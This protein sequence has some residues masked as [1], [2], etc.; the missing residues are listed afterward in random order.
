ML[1]PLL[2]ALA[3]A[4]SPA[5]AADFPKAEFKL[6]LDEYS[7]DTM[8]FR[9]PSGLRVL[10][11]VD[12]T[13]P[14]VTVTNWFDRGSIHD[15]VNSKGESVEGIAHAVEHLAFRA[16]HG[17][18]PKN[19]DVINQLGGNL[20]AFTNQDATVYLT[21]APVDA[22]VPLL[23]IEAMRMDNGVR[24]VTAEDVEAEKA[25][26]RNELR[27]GYES[28]ANGNAAVRTA[29]KEIGQLL[30]P[31]DHPY[32]NSTI[33]DH[34]TIKN[35]DLDSVQRFVRE[36][37]RPEYATMA[38]VGDFDFKASSPMRM[39]FQAF[40]G[41]EHLLMAPEDAEA[42]KKLTSAAE[43]ND[44]MNGWMPKLEAHLQKSYE[45][46]VQPRIDCSN[47]AEPPP[48]YSDETITIKGMVD[49]PTAV[50]A[51]S[52]PHGYCGDDTTMNIAA[53]LL[54]NYIIRT[55]SPSTNA[56]SQNSSIDMTGCFANAGVL[57][58]MVMCFA[59]QGDVD[60]S[61]SADRLLDKIADSLYLQW[62]PIDPVFKPF[63]DQNF[64]YSK[65]YSMQS[66]LESTDNIAS[67]YGRS[68]FIAEHA[69]Y[70]GRV[71]YFSDN[72]NAYS[73]I[74]L[75]PARELA[76]KY[77]TRDRMVRMII[78]PIDEEERE[79]LEAGASEADKENEVAGEHRAKD[80][81]S[82]QLF[83]PDVL[84]PEAIASVTVTPDVED[85]NIFTLDNGLEVVIMPH[86]SAPLVKVGLFVDGSDASAPEYGL[87]K[88]SN[89]LF[90]TATT[91][92]QNPTEDPLAIA[93]WA[94]RGNNSATASGSSKNL[95]ALLY[96]L[97][98]HVEDYDWQ[99]AK[100]MPKVRAWRGSAKGSGKKPETWASRLRAERLFPDHPYGKWMRPSEYD[101]MESWG[102]DEVKS[103]VYT[104]WQPKNAQMVIVGKVDAEEAEKMVREYWSSWAAKGGV[105][106]G[107]QKPPPA[108]A[109]QPER[110][111]LLFD[112]P[113]STQSKVQV[114]CQLK[115]NGL[116]DEARDKVI[117]KVFTFLAFEKLREEAGLTYGA[118]AFPRR[119]WGDS[120]ELIL[121]SVIQNSGVGF[122]VENLL[123][124][125]ESGANGDL[126]EDLITTNKWNVA[127]TSVT[128]LQS[129]F[130][131]MGAIAEPGRG[132]LDYFANYPKYLST[133]DKASVQDA[134]STCSGH[135]VV[136]VV[137]PVESVEPQL[138]ERNIP[139][140]VIDWENLYMEQLSKKEQKK[141]LKAKAKEEAEAAAK[142]K[143]E[144]AG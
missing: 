59:E 12:H 135:E 55:I 79:R 9:F 65:L 72:I 130:Q 33:G 69:H 131:M 52:L 3:L 90:R 20:N 89:A 57:G 119:Y 32:Q 105:T 34:E 14:I 51:W 4:P 127:R 104:K 2:T 96:K 87:D 49:Y 58:S 45:T 141:Y 8:D 38:V 16:K 63:I 61:L 114:S 91:T 112:K 138:K 41:V 50:T 137:G 68:A 7:I 21:V 143:E 17:D 109:K 140:E 1:L 77:L 5:K 53:N 126:P 76:K 46:P 25:I 83:D 132:N 11:Q 54:T 107:A 78:E 100:K 94:S 10:F 75:E 82:R 27:M 99:M 111:V 92:N 23:R 64:N 136:T 18:L 118:Y 42:Y 15:G 81:A 6:K 125:I 117:G 40:E 60:S 66:V 93:G 88:F 62:Q 30:Y 67:L 122:G 37:Y 95:D 47:R 56:F 29:F 120:T 139:Y 102:L 80:D 144:S 35:I 116:K 133:V 98:W 106:E 13:Q 110:Q 36:N 24:N 48:R 28:G 123:G 121:A 74:A 26:V 71:T 19:W 142:R 39:V 86:G 113:I 85:M 44:F 134:L 124:I 128:G 115:H 129:G 73:Q 70:T 108:P 84:T 31:P 103:W 101:K 97:R 22:A 43:R